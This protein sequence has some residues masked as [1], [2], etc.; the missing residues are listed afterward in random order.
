MHRF[1]AS[2]TRPVLDALEPRVAIEIGAETGAHTKLLVE[3][4]G[5]HGGEL[6]CVDPAPK[7]DPDVFRAEYGER[8][9]MHTDLSLDALGDVGP[10]DAV[11]IDG[12]HNWY[13]VINELRQ[14]FDRAQAERKPSPVV[15][16]HDIGWPYGRRD[17]YYLPETIP[18]SSR[19]P[20]ARTGLSPD[21]SGTLGSKGFNAHL[22]NALQEGGEANGVLTAVE[23]FVRE[24]DEP[25]TLVTLPGRPRPR[26]PRSP[27][28][29]AGEAS[30]S[31]HRSG[32]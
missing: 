5:Q 28:G 29:D 30:R 4:L 26:N 32:A 8:F 20:H 21:E 27:I 7:F 9:T 2:I 31:R 17:L 23:D 25:L 19:H 1:W 24:R 10:A 16:F 15:F 6:H 22:E 11:L 3:L 18:D 14:V 12:D 13:T